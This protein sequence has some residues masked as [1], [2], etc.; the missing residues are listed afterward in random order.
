[1]AAEMAAE[2]ATEMNAEKAAAMAAEM[3]TEMC[4][5]MAAKMAIEMHS[6]MAAKMASEMATTLGKIRGVRWLRKK[7][8]IERRRKKDE[9]RRSLPGDRDESRQGET[10]RTVAE[11]ERVRAGQRKEVDRLENLAVARRAACE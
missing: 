7:G 6:E 1:M 9:L 11:D 5:E 8:N 10:R 3:A 2:T 4:A